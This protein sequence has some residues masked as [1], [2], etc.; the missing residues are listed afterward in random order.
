MK[1]LFMMLGL[2]LLAVPIQAKADTA[3]DYTGFTSENVSLFGWEP[4]GAGFLGGPL[5]NERLGLAQQFNINQETQMSFLNVTA[6][7][8]PKQ[9]TTVFNY[10]L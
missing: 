7:V 5:S 6:T 4:G 10:R 1:K 3:F 2:M 8:M 9:G